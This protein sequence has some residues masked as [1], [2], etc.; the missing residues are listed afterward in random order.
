MKVKGIINKLSRKYLCSYEI[1]L[2]VVK[3]TP[4]KSVFLFAENLTPGCPGGSSVLGTLKLIN[5]YFVLKAIVK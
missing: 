2:L 1:F 5:R 3:F 4:P